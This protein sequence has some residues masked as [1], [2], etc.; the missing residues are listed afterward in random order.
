VSPEWK[1]KIGEGTTVQWPVGLGGKGNE[2]VSG[3]VTQT[4]GSLG[5]VELIYALQNKI[6]Y[7]SVQ[8]MAGE[9]VRADVKSVS[10]A[11]AEAA[12]K[13]PADFRVSITN[14]PGKGVYPISS[15]TWLLL[16]ETPKDKNQSKIMVDFMTWALSEGQKFAPALG[17]APLPDAVVKLEL[18]ALKKIKVS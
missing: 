14:A 11:A 10:A 1:E 4:P 15:F 9:F 5:Y 6:A 3:L 8:N 18:A 12:A 16:Y 2:G 7:G 13:M 17:Y